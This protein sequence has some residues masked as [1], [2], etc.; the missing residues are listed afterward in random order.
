MKGNALADKVFRDNGESKTDTGKSCILGK[1]SQLDRTGTC[2]F[3]LVNAVRH[4]FLCDVC[5]VSG[6]VDDHCT[7]LVCV[8]YPLLKFVLCDR[9]TTR[10]VREAEIDQVRCLYRK[11]R[12][13]SIGFQTR[14]V[15]H[16]IKIF[17]FLVVFAGTSCHYVCV[18][19]N[20]INR[21]ADCYF[22]VCAKDLLNVSGVTLRSVGYKDLIRTDLASACLVIIFCDRAS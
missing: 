19:I 6:V 15:D 4:I 17:V 21:V 16:S 7:V 11:F 18:Y 5:L 13:E 10:V 1:A 8:V 14:H 22:I 12:Q 9:C 20:R 3:T 2:T